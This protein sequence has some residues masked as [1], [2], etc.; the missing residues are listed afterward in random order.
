MPDF[1]FAEPASKPVAY[2]L[3]TYAI[4]ITILFFPSIALLIKK[5]N[6][7]VISH[8]SVVTL[9]MHLAFA[10]VLSITQIASIIY[11]KEQFCTAVNAMFALFFYFIMHFMMVTPTIFFQSKVNRD[12][13]T[14]DRSN[15]SLFA[16]KF[17][18]LRMRLIISFIF[19][20]LHLALF[21]FLY[22]FAHIEPYGDCNRTAVVAYATSLALI[23]SLITYFAFKLIFVSD[24]F[25]MRFELFAS[26]IVHMP[27][28]IALSIAYGYFAQGFPSSFDY[29]WVIPMINLPVVLVNAVF[30]ICLT[31][32]SFFDWMVR[33]TTKGSIISQ[34]SQ[35]DDINVD[36]TIFTLTQSRSADIVQTIFD[37]EIM[38]EGLKAFSITHWSVENVMFYQAVEQYRSHFGANSDIDRRTA[39]EIHDN[40]IKVG[41]MTE[42]NID[43]VSRRKITTIINSNSEL[44]DKEVFD[45]A[46]LHIAN[47]MKTDTIV[48]WQATVDF[49]NTLQK[50]I[51]QSSLDKV[52]PLQGKK[53]RTHMKHSTSQ[54][55]SSSSSLPEAHTM[56]HTDSS[57]DAHFS[58]SQLL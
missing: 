32:D 43:Y 3:Y 28:S 50:A 11:G 35:I 9:I 27:T 45:R 19:G 10:Y 44:L 36:S 7:R 54:T 48:K 31:Y 20:T 52:R 14:G 42:V 56:A 40:Y 38:L 34:T 57:L 58:N 33:K 37:N 22:F 4:V 41:A 5:R 8:R 16:H 18:Q 39:I 46:Q 12:K 25:F 21:L 53:S 13:A 49:R 17:T 29:R 2:F 51:E 15:W 30:P 23:S 6:H 47:L 1:T 55:N 24:P 26:I